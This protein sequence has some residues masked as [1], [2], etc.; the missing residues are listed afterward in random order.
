[1]SFKNKNKNK[2]NQI[3]FFK[4]KIFFYLFI[5]FYFYIYRGKFLYILK[6]TMILFTAQI[7]VVSLLMITY[8]FYQDSDSFV[9]KKTNRTLL[10]KSYNQ[11]L[12]NYGSFALAFA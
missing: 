11:S 10:L 6:S 8:G 2:P 4:K 12:V 9:E 7:F 3:L 1:M 5:F